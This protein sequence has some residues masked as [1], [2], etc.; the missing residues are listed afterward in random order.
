MSHLPALF[1]ALIWIW[2]DAIG[3]LLSVIST[4]FY[5]GWEGTPLLVPK[6]FGLALFAF[7]GPLFYRLFLYRFSPERTS[8]ILLLLLFALY[9]ALSV[10][11]A[12]DFFAWGTLLACW[13]GGI[14]LMTVLRQLR[15]VE[16]VRIWVY[17]LQTAFFFY[18]STRISQGG[19]PLLL[20]APQGVG[21]VSWLMLTA[22]VLV[23]LFLPRRVSSVQEP[24]RTVAPS[25]LISR[26]RGSLGVVFG[27]LMGLSVGIIE[28]LHIWSAR[29]P[30]Y[31]AAIYL[32]SLA[33]GAF[34]GHSLW[35]S[36]LHHLFKLA[37]AGVGT[38]IGIY[39]LLYMDLSAG[40]SL[41]HVM[42]LSLVA[43]TLS[44]MGLMA[45]WGLFLQRMLTYQK[46]QASFFPWAS[47]QAGFVFLLLILAMFLLKANPAGFWVALFL[48]LGVLALHER[49]EASRLDLSYTGGGG[50]SRLWMYTCGLFFLVGAV[51]LAA[52]VPAVSPA[53]PPTK[54]LA[55]TASFGVMSSNI[56]YGWTDDYRFEPLAHM[57]YLRDHAPEILGLQEVNKGHTSGAY[58]DLFRL[59][60]QAM[61]GQWF[62][63]DA[64]YGFGNSLL[65]RFKVIH[66]ENRVF[67]AK[68][69]L[70]RACLMNTIEV[71]GQA[72]TVMVT[73]VSHLEAPNPVRQAQVDEL[74]TWIRDLDTPW[75]LIGDFNATPES[76]EIQQLAALSHPVY[77][78]NP[79]W[80]HTFSFPAISPSR[81]IDY[82]FFSKDFEL[83]R[84]EILDN[85]GS[86]DHRP[87]LAK[88]R[89]PARETP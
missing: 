62:F 41:Q 19:L 25:L 48:S 52:P 44:A 73:H 89:L 1:F 78:E 17:A 64:H 31:P 67:Q 22:L 35:R 83:E 49:G 74:S 85:Q 37:L 11:R 69:M 77:R 58:T 53:A 65:S 39:V 6:I 87:V 55:E 72:V 71:N 16:D 8:R 42:L 80:L 20:L 66:S 4:Y 61:P 30:M 75:I 76:A 50:I 29:T 81:R 23:G 86:S 12:S 2:S 32:L 3:A 24:V 45:C 43:H 28:N 5:F 21:W 54:T 7:S 88:L 14:T 60:Q 56:R 82:I 79:E 57:R 33:L 47:L 63:G 51:S 46:A 18:L 59:Y 10:Q 68:D 70:K 36:S 38:A 27:L 40:T 15:D 9:T 26:W 13:L 34:L 84:M